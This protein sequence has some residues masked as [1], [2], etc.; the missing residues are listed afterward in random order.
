[1]FTKFDAGLAVEI[2]EPNPGSACLIGGRLMLT[3]A[4]VV[5][6]VGSGC[7]IR[8]KNTFGVVKAQ[9]V[10][11]AANADLALVELPNNIES[12]PSRFGKFPAWHQSHREIDLPVSFFGYPEWA[13]TIKKNED[14]TTTPFSGGRQIGG[15]IYLGD[16]S[17]GDCKINCVKG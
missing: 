13:T 11:V 8:S 14:G 4:H 16:E 6:D 7:E 1:M 12:S 17:P 3:S 15:F 9:V 2:T 10:W 5:G